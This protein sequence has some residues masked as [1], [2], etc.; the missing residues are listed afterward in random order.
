[1]EERNFETVT[2]LKSSN[3]IS[4]TVF[5]KIR[6][7]LNSS[8][9]EGPLMGEKGHIDPLMEEDNFETVSLNCSKI[10]LFKKLSKG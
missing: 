9:F 2:L 1:M 10:L 7:E 5:F 6:Q 3:Y 4:E 8:F